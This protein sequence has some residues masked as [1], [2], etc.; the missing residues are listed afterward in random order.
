MRVKPPFLA[1]KPFLPF[2]CVTQTLHIPLT[3]ILG[4][5]GQCT[6]VKLSALCKLLQCS[7]ALQHKTPH[8]TGYWDNNSRLLTEKK[9]Y[10]H[11]FGWLSFQTL[12]LLLSG[13]A[14]HHRYHWKKKFNYSIQDDYFLL[15]YGH[16]SRMKDISCSKWNEEVTTSSNLYLSPQNLFLKLFIKSLVSFNL[17]LLK[18][19]LQLRWPHLLLPQF[20]S[21]LILCFIPFRG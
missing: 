7:G 9:P 15:R 14:L 18:L 4:L 17:Q 21:F 13:S 11:L 12:L 20:T 10:F 1:Q 3:C 2:C 6:R 16:K 8:V 5:H 19:L